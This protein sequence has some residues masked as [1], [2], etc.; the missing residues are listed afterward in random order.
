M[1][2][3]DPLLRDLPAG[4]TLEEVN[5]AIAVEYGQAMIVNVNRADGETLSKL[6][7]HAISTRF[8]LVIIFQSYIAVC[9]C[10][11]SLSQIQFGFQ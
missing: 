1:L 9:F 3:E 6:L 2:Q 5:S 8:F 7:V 10:D 11:R 4:V